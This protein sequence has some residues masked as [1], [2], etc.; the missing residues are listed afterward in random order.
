MLLFY[1]ENANQLCTENQ[2]MSFFM[3]RLFG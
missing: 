2:N 3:K 1:E